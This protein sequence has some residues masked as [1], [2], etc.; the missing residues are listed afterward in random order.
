MKEKDQDKFKK[1][2]KVGANEQSCVLTKVKKEH[3]YAFRVYAENEAGISQEFAANVGFVTV[4]DKALSKQKS[5][6]SEEPPQI[7]TALDQE[8]KINVKE[9]IKTQKI[10]LKQVF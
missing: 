6:S 7:K 9:D 10:D 2:M 3:E 1:V 8:E 5:A 4:P